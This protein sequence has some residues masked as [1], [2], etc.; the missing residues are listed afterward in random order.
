MENDD[1]YNTRKGQPRDADT[2]PDKKVLVF[3]KG[4]K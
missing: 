4:S 1:R 3:G 2:V